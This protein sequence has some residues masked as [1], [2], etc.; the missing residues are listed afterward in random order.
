MIRFIQSTVLVVAFVFIC[1]VHSAHAT[2]NATAT[3]T[4]TPQLASKQ[5]ICKTCKCDAQNALIDCSAQKLNVTFPAELWAPIAATGTNKTRVTFAGN[6]IQTVTAFPRL[7]ITHLDLSDN[8]IAVILPNAFRNLSATLVELDLSANLLTYQ[9]LRPDAFIG[10]YA[11]DA[12]EP[13]RELRILR[14]A[15][16]RLHE[17]DQDLFEHLPALET[18]TLNGNSFRTIGYGAN[19]A[20][21]RVPYLRELDLSNMELRELPEHL[22]H[23]LNRLKVLHLG[24]NLFESLPTALG[25]AQSVEYL[26]L[27][28]NPLGNLTGDKYV[29]CFCIVDICMYKF[30]I[31]LSFYRQRLSGNAQSPCA[32]PQLHDATEEH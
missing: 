3:A 20:I 30:C 27:D 9:S 11:P 17:L 4:P 26:N 19:V 16:N 18:L 23:T 21:S 12:Y 2:N 13:L 24:G 10:K 32:R 6:G 15:H 7:N 31:I 25:Y 22:L 5:T 8:R 14:L 28:E 1:V 29:V